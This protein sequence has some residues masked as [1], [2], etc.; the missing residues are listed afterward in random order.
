MIDW[1]QVNTEKDFNI[2]EFNIETEMCKVG[3]LLR[4]YA[5]LASDANM[6]SAQAK[7]QRDRVYAAASIG[8]RLHLSENKEKATN[9]A[10]K[11]KV[12][13]NE[14]YQQAQE[15]Y[16]LEERDAKKSD[17]YFRSMKA[18]TDTLI[19]LSYHQRTVIKSDGGA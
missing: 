4:F 12:L 18:K 13:L 8:I 16:L 15:R 14:T 1:T 19:A 17:L 7:D 5:D 6:R 3:T 9:D 10:V 11:E 2:D